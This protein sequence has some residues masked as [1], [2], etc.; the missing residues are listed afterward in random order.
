MNSFDQFI[1]DSARSYLQSVVY[2]DDKIY[3]PS[4]D[5]IDSV[6]N[7]PP[8]RDPFVSPEVVSNEKTP[9]MADELASRKADDLESQYAHPRQLTESFAEMGIVC[10]FYQPS[11]NASVDEYSTIFKL[12]QRT[13]IVVLDWNLYKDGGS[14]VSL[15]IANLITQSAADQPHHVRLCT[16]YTDKPDL[17]ST[18]KELLAYLQTFKCLETT[19]DYDRLQLV[20]GSTRISILGKPGVSRP[21]EIQEKFEVPERQLATRLL[22]DFCEMHR[23]L[24]SGLALK[25]LSSIRKNTKRLLDKFTC[26]LDGSFVLHRALVISDR[27]ALEELP[28]LLADELSAILEDSLLSDFE[29]ES[30]MSDFIDSL[31]LTEPCEGQFNEVSV[32]QQLKSGLSV[33]TEKQIRN[34]AKMIGNSDQSSSEKLGLLYSNRTQYLSGMPILKFGTIVRHK[35]ISDNNHNWKYSIC[36]MPI[37]DSRYRFKSDTK[38]PE[39]MTFPFWSLHKVHM[40]TDPAA[41][42]IQ[43]N[44][45]IISL[46]AGIKI[47]DN[48]WLDDVKFGED[49][50][51]RPAAGTFKYE[52]I[53]DINEIHWVAQLKPLHAQ[54]IALHVGSEASRVGV[55]ESE[56]L[57]LVLQK[58]PSEKPKKPEPPVS[59]F[60]LF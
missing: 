1:K 24:L 51:A 55:T 22:D 28:E 6:D 17:F 52:V 47:R 14:K 3:P 19:C 11:E 40:K 7:I 20:S 34:Y 30:V 32:R 58:S 25:G 36:L 23:G 4:I 26:E 12:C 38:Q 57:R 43:D 2:I 16:I 56:W 10:A 45:H 42:V 46:S 59:Q 50:W 15:L 60:V 21:A 5:D 48:L 27:E 29:S 33:K 53:G 31:D 41:L 35:K 9:S 13:D 44:H 49:G 37:C 8:D 39:Y 54:R 18:A